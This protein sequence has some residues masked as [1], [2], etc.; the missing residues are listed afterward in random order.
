MD[1][2]FKF[3]TIVGD[4]FFTDRVEEK[5]YVAEILHSANH[6][7][8]VSPRRY[9]KSSLIHEVLKHI[10]RPSLFINLQSVTSI[11]QLAGT[12]I[13]HTLSDFP[14]ERMKYYLNHFRFVPTISI[15]PLTEGVDIAFQPGVDSQILLEDAF[16]LIEKVG[17]RKRM[18]VVFDEFQ[19]IL[20][21]DKQLDKQLRALMQEQQNVN[22]VMLGSQ[23]SMMIR[24]FEKKKSPFYHFGILMRLQKIPYSDFMEYISSRLQHVCDKANA[25]RI[26]KEVLDFTQ[27]HSYY[28]QQLSFQIWSVLQKREA[29]EAIVKTAVNEVINQHDFDY[30][31][32]WQTLGK[33]DKRTMQLLASQELTLGQNYGMPSSTLFSSLKRLTE[34]GFLIKEKTYQ[35]DDPFFCQWVKAHN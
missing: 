5:Q 17:E 31:R 12:I 21:I 18:I 1:N 27:C 30:E 7:I 23:E 4:S 26:A 29:D 2:P 15:N 14:V 10:N 20:N 22:Y 33:T 32:L 13:R 35:I 25:D 3:G 28:A 24:I 9:G 11:Q 6:L 8:L 34:Q 19:E 16:A